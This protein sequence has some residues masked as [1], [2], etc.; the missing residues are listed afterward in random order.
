MDQKIVYHQTLIV[1]GCNE[2]VLKVGEAV[3][4]GDGS[5]WAK[6]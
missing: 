1:D 3:A 5:K 6:P 4:G 2:T